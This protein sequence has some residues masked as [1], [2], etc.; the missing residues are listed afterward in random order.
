MG[1]FLQKEPDFEIPEKPFLGFAN[2]TYITVLVQQ[3]YRTPPVKQECKPVHNT[4][5]L[6]PD[7]LRSS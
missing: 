6:L 3:T 2:S 1:F 5:H 7:I 4:Q